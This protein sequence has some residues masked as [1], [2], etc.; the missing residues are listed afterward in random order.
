MHW[1]HAARPLA[2]SGFQ[3]ASYP[4]KDGL[5]DAFVSTSYLPGRGGNNSNVWLRENRANHQ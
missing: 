1:N 2:L 4:L 5:P 3:P